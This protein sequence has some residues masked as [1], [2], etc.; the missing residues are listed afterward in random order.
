MSLAAYPE[1]QHVQAV[2]GQGY[3]GRCSKVVSYSNIVNSRLT[4][5]KLASLFPSDLGLFLG[6]WSA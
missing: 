6:F 4:K 2:S 1:D 5:M 3:G